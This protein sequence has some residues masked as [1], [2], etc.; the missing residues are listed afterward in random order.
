MSEEAVQAAER[1]GDKII[2]NPG[3][4]AA[5][6]VVAVASDEFPPNSE[7]DVEHPALLA[8]LANQGA[9]L[10]PAGRIEA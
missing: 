3:W 2:D 4:H 6:R 8:E 7:D 9:Q 10:A 5:A 1:S